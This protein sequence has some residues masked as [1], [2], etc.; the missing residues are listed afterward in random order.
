MSKCRRCGCEYVASASA[1]RKGDYE[2]VPCLNA[3]QR[4]WRAKRKAEGNPVKHT[5]MSREYHAAYNKDYY[6]KKE[7][8]ERQA[9]KAKARRQS[10]LELHKHKARWQT[11]HAIESGRLIKQPCER[12]GSNEAIE[13]H[14]EDY[15]E[16]LSVRWLCRKHHSDEHS[17][18][19]GGQ[20]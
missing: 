5:R 16:P 14:H 19:T 1:I 17:K 12:C 11:N 10:P 7:V 13:A 9:A 3:R 2:C 20:S 6:Q 8:K 18:A 15:N 4:A